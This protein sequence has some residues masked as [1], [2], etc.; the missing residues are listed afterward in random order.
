MAVLEK[1]KKE[2]Q[3]KP[4]V[5]VFIALLGV[6]LLAVSVAACTRVEVATR[7]AEPEETAA[8]AIEPTATEPSSSGEPV[9]SEQG[10]ITTASGLQYIEIQAGDGPAP[11]AGE[12]VAVHYTGAL[13]DGTVFDSSV[14]RGTPFQFA[15]GRGMVIPGWDEGIALMKVGGKA[16]L[17]IPPELAYGE[18]GAGG[19]IPPNATLIFEV[20]LISILP[21]SPDNFTEVAEADYV[22][23]DSGLKYYDLEVGDGPA[24][25]VGQQVL[26]HYTAWLDDGTK[27]DSSLDQG[28]A[29]AFVLGA[30]QVLP[31]WDEG[32]ATMQVGGKRQ[33]VVPPALAFGD[34]GAGGVIPPGATLIFEMELVDVQ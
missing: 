14:E 1:S 12:V 11:Q 5:S 16:R 26:V 8:V 22:T 30:G 13:T 33:L 2:S 21:G 4:R 15:L 25:Q 17:V 29:I 18:S 7:T 10:G 23:T 9:A 6:T 32:V 19:V 34:E 3:V 28:Q 31:G 20:E 24:P 27:I